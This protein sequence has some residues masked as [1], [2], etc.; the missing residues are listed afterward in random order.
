MLD[1][2]SILET[3]KATRAFGGLLAVS[4]VSISIAPE[5]VHGIVG[6]NGAGK[7]TLFNLITGTDR[8]SSG[9][10]WL[11]G[12]EVTDARTATRVQLGMSRT[13]QASRLFHNLSV[14]ENLLLARYWGR[15]GTTLRSTA[16]AVRPWR[17]VGAHVDECL[18]LLNQMGVERYA[19]ASPRELP[20]GIQRRVEISRALATQPRVLLMDEPAAGLNAEEVEDLK[21]V[22]VD[23]RRGSLTI[24]VV[25]HNVDMIQD[26]SDRVS[27]MDSGKLIFEGPPESA[28]A[29]ADVRRAYFGK[30]NHLDA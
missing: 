22:V 28:F 5:S 16:W 8:P 27:V 9:E 6:P 17:R 3:R 24:V 25:D 11:E 12:R 21:A 19:Q 20:Y 29:D 23:L 4:D 30:R 10:I 18:T 13:F 2:P 1:V 26:I 15:H 14:I 7:T